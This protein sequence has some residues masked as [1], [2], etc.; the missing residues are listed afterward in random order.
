MNDNYHQELKEKLLPILKCTKCHM[1]SLELV[2]GYPDII[3]PFTLGEEFIYCSKC[4]SRFPVTED[5][6]PIMWTPELL[7]I[8]TSQTD[9]ISNL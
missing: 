5:G 8:L 6:I 3:L 7:N 4:K 9:N 2:K 1:N